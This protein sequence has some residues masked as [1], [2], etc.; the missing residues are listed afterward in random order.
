MYESMEAAIRHARFM[1]KYLNKCNTHY[2]IRLALKEIGTTAFAAETVGSR[3]SNF[4]AGS[5]KRN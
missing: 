2:V 1:A 5:T 4:F 3:A